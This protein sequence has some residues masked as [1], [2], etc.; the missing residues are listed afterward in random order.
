MTIGAFITSV[1]AGLLAI[2]LALVVIVPT[3]VL[4]RAL[5]RAVAR[6]RA[7]VVEPDNC[8]DDGGRPT[9]NP[10]MACKISL[11]DSIR[12]AEKIGAGPL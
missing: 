10:R 12:Y 8:G 9:G 1:L 7:R 6:K 3:W 11:S 4:V 5:C 2:V